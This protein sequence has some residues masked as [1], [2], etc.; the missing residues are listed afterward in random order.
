MTKEN[1]A[2][3]W[4]CCCLIKNVR[5]AII[6]KQVNH[7]HKG[8]NINNEDLS[9]CEI[10]AIRMKNIKITVSLIEEI[11]FAIRKDRR[12]SGLE[13]VSQAT[14]CIYSAIKVETVDEPRKQY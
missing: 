7:N 13:S 11:L 3:S 10:V 6:Y 8:R 1:S 9:P 4:K 2:S 14:S 12:Y 5:Q